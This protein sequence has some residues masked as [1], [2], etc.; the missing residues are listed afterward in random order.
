MCVV[1]L[2][3]VFQVCKGIPSQVKELVFTG[4]YESYTIGSPATGRTI[5]A[6]QDLSEILDHEGYPGPP[7]W[8]LSVGLPSLP[9][10]NSFVL[11]PWHREA[12]AQKWIEA[13]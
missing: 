3:L 8:G 9:C 1:T 2:L 7:G 12:M 4:V 5:Y 11:K 6:G 13:Q 10:K